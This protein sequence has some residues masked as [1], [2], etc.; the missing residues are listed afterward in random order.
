M[1]VRGQIVVLV[2]VGISGL[3]FMVDI[4]RVRY[5]STKVST[6]GVHKVLFSQ[7]YKI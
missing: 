1:R 6:G 3:S 7:T 2:K 4:M 5:L